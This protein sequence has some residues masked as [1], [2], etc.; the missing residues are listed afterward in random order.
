MLGNAFINAST[1]ISSVG[2]YTNFTKPSSTIQRMKWNT[3]A[4]KDMVYIGSCFDDGVLSGPVAGHITLFVHDFS[5]LNQP[6]TLS[7]SLSSH[8]CSFS[9]ICRFLVPSACCCCLSPSC[10]VATSPLCCSLPT[11][12]YSPGALSNCRLGY[13]RLH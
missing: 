12:S 8:C 7:R 9:A 13:T 10:S 5:D 1:I 4:E 6:Y 3:E 2:Q 11:V